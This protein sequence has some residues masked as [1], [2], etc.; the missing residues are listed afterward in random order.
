MKRFNEDQFIKELN[1]APWDTAFIFDDINDM[2]DSWELIFNSIL[3]A[4]CPWREKRVKRATQTPWMTNSI[5]KQLQLRDNY[6]KI[7]RRSNSADDWTN[8][9]IARNSAVN[10]L[11]N[12][13][14]NYYENAF[15]EN[16]KKPARSLE[17]NKVIIRN[18]KN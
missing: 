16:K 7:A 6:L 5:L 17:D 13:T 4:N 8:Y 9:R 2:L 3:D 1:Q 15:T 11:R 10:M 12:A 18:G 14:R